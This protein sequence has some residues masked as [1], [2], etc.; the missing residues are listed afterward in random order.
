MRERALHQLTMA[1]PIN[2]TL[3]GRGNQII[4]KTQDN[5]YTSL[6]NNT[7][8]TIDHDWFKKTSNRINKE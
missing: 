8:N 3:Y 2:I 6:I 4:N 1:Q 5:T 7:E